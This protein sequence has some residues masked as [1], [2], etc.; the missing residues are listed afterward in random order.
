MDLYYV[1]LTNTFCSAS[2]QLLG[3]T[4]LLSPFDTECEKLEVCTALGNDLGMTTSTCCTDLNAVAGTIISGEKRDVAANAQ[5]CD[6][7][8]ACFD[9]FALALGYAEQQ[10]SGARTE[11]RSEARRE[12]KRRVVD[13]VIP[14]V[15]YIVALLSLV[16]ISIPSLPLRYAI[17]T[18]ERQLLTAF[19]TLVA[20]RARARS[21]AIHRPMRA[22]PGSGR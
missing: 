17:L 7:R 19:A 22:F 18:R 4:T 13:V 2:E 20:A 8:W 9:K 3:I 21:A 12:V 15:I 14:L 6:T 10:V 5:R 16:G 1:L 11:A